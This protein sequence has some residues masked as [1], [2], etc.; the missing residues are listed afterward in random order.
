MKTFTVIALF[1]L[2]FTISSCKKDDHSENAAELIVGKWFF[3]KNYEVLTRNGQ[4]T[5]STS[6]NFGS[7]IYSDVTSSP[8]YLHTGPSPYYRQY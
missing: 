5:E 6:A 3:K 4:K 2:A 7:E 8:T 1:L